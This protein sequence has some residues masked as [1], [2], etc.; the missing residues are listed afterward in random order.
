MNRKRFGLR[1]E[2]KQEEVEKLNEEDMKEEGKALGK[3]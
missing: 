1:K 2:L 3:V